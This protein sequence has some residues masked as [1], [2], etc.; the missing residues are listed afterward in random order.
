MQINQF[1]VSELLAFGSL[2]ATL[3]AFAFA[4]FRYV[5]IKRKEQSQLRFENYHLLIH[6]LVNAGTDGLKVDSQRAIIFELRNYKEY[7]EITVRILEGLQKFWKD[8]EILIEEIERT[9]KHLKPW[10]V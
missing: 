5:D 3:F 6:K 10:Y 1:T 7:K 4:S 8:N 2:L 9:L